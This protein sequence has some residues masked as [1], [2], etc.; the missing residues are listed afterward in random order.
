MEKIVITNLNY[1]GAEHALDKLDELHEE[2]KY[3]GAGDIAVMVEK[4]REE[5]RQAVFQYR[6]EVE[7][8][9]KSLDLKPGDILKQ[10]GEDKIEFINILDIVDGIAIYNMLVIGE[11]IEYIPTIGLKV[12][13]LLHCLAYS[14]Y[15]VEKTTK[16]EYDKYYKVIEKLSKIEIK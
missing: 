9:A 10:V 1:S 16:E 4:L 14:G 2:L 12:Y 15:K 3:S 6:K 11:R 5:I 7:D 13:E 8:I